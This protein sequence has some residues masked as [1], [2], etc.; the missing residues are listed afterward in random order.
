M[1]IQIHSVFLSV[2]Q[3][4]ESH[5][6]ITIPPAPVQA[7]FDRIQAHSSS[8]MTETRKPAWRE[9]LDRIPQ[10][11]WDSLFP[12]HAWGDAAPAIAASKDDVTQD[13]RRFEALVVREGSTKEEHATLEV[14]TGPVW[15]SDDH[16]AMELRIVNRPS[17]KG[18]VFHTLLRNTRQRPLIENPG[19]RPLSAADPQATTW[20]TFEYP[21]AKD[22]LARWMEEGF[23]RIPN[24]PFRLALFPGKM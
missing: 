2:A 19:D 24:L 11:I 3:A 17:G 22:M 9:L 23:A 10:E 15:V 18:E 4:P 8:E 5:P 21:N 12:K 16:L 6:D 1:S 14:V 13:E 20:I 7:F